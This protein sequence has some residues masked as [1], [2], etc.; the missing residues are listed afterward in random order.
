M[1]R[2]LVTGGAG[3]IGSHIVE[4]LLKDGHFVRVLDNFSS[5]RRENL[6]FTRELTNSRT[7]ELIKG[8]ICDKDI[9]IESTREI[10]FVLH[11][12]AL[13]SVPKSMREPHRYNKVNIDGTLNMLEASKDNRVK[14]FVFASSSS[15]YGEVNNS[16]EKE[17]FVPAPISP[18]ALSKLTGEHYCKIFSLY[19]DLPCV[20]LRY[21]NVFGPRQALDDEYAVVI[22]KFINCL[23]NDERPP[24]FGNGKQSRDFTFVENVVDANLLAAKAKKVKYGVFNVAGGKNTSILELAK[25]LNNILGKRIQPLLLAKRP[26][27]VFRTLADMSM[28][29]RL[30]KFKPKI[31]FIDGLNITVDYWKNNA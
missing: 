5:G 29:H 2:F 17:S 27:D 3:F 13:R 28:S 14:R 24:I 22:P 11:Q 26:G 30:L 31:D 1:K 18:Y 16:P 25:I 15:V 10:D 6:S 19:H 9:C 7:Y 4:R 20:A 8:D 12:A 23:L 21:F